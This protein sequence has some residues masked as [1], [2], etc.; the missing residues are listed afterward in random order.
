V[1]GA[2]FGIETFT[3]YDERPEADPLLGDAP[4]LPSSGN[5]PI[6]GHPYDVNRFAGRAKLHVVKT[7]GPPTDARPAIYIVRDGR[8]ATASYF[9]YHRD[10]LRKE[11]TLR[12]VICGRVGFGSW[13]RH[14]AQWNPQRRPNTLLLRFEQL[15][16]DPVAQIERIGAFL[17]IDPVLRRVPTFEELHRTAPK[18][19]RSGRL[20]SWKTLFT[21]RDHSLLWDLHGDEMRAFGYGRDRTAESTGL[22]SFLRRRRR[23]VQRWSEASRTV[24]DAGRAR[25]RR[26]VLNLARPAASQPRAA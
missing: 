6:V 19:F 4:P 22:S 24:T 9:H 23:I 7:H 14:L 8:E 3:L 12:D 25:A 13:G 26:I 10:V 5:E 20:D 18:F 21:E 1:L 11:V 17:G 2:L 16:A 15:T